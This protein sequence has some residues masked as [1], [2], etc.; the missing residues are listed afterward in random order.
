MPS[1]RPLIGPVDHLTA[2]GKNAT[3]SDP[4]RLEPRTSASLPAGAREL[5]ASPRMVE[6]PCPL[7]QSDDWTL[8]L[9]ATDT[10]FGFPGT[11]TVARCSA[12]DMLY[13][14]PQVAPDCLSAFYPK[15]YSAHA[16]DRAQRH[17]ER[18]GG[19]D[20]WDAI[21]PRK[22]ARLLDV[23]C[24]SGAYLLRQQQ[25]GWKVSGIE[26]APSAAE[27]ARRLGLD[28]I[29]C[30]DVASTPL[31]AGEFDMITMLGAFDHVPEP[32]PTLR[33]LYAACAVGGRF[34]VTVPNAGGAAALQ[35]GAS[36]PGW[37]LPRHQNH[38][39]PATLRD[40]LEKA[41]FGRIEIS[42]KRRTSHWRRAARIYSEAT[43]SRWWRIVASSRNL[44]GLIARLYARGDA[45]DDIIAVAAKTSSV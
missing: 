45:A 21:P 7:C 16:P 20:P 26:P 23:G 10:T 3:M 27:A 22:G 41:G 37:D 17:V 29:W 39:T 4:A 40:M 18:R 24:G 19:T 6:R 15:D 43:G 13:T 25:L 42:G 1:Y 12:C 33:A 44:A 34:I 32:L 14:R 35:F 38:F 5:G 30:G 28:P 9:R 31:S 8:Q 11:F 2:R 36:W